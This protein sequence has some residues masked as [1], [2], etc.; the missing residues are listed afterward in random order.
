MLA[1]LNTYASTSK[2]NV[3][4]IP[5][6]NLPRADLSL[7]PELV[8]V[9]SHA[10]LKP[11][12]LITLSDLPPLKHR[13][14]QL[15]PERTRW[16]LVDHNALQGELGSVYGI[17]LVGCIDHH[18]EEGKVPQETSDEP[19]IVKKSGSCSSLVVEFCKEAWDALSALS[20]SNEEIAWDT[21]LAYLALAP[22]LIDTSNLTDASKVTQVDTEAVKYLESKIS[23]TETNFE[24]EKYFKELSE[25]KQNIGDLSLRDILRKDYKQWNEVGSTT[26]GISSVVKDLQFLIDKAGS[27]EKFLEVLKGFAE[28]REL[29]ICSIMT[30]SNPDGKFKRE[31]FVWGVDEEGVK[32]AKIFEEK[33]KQKLGLEQWRDGSLDSE[34]NAQWRR[35][36][37]QERVENSRKQVAP[38]LRA[39]ASGKK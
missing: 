17:R 28:E 4:Y 27:Q 19:R 36:W 32:A 34:D 39:A 29:S 5:L 9:L 25:A 31:L 2:S 16:L 11:S 8:P 12:D 20:K 13:P 38:L 10:H 21:E 14:L 22:A 23:R 1:Y 30:T 24:P 3:L 6:S 26:F 18:D 33:C 37:K 7:R 15:A 35:S